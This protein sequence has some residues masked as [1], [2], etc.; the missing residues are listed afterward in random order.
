[1]IVWNIRGASN[2]LARV[3]CKELVRKF[4]PVF[5]IV[6]ETHSPFQHLKLFWE[7]LGYH[8]VGI[9]EAEGHKGG[10]WFLSSM[11][12]VCCKFIDT[13][14]QGVTV[15]VQFDNLIWRCSGIYGSP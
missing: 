1:M 15:E 6:V 2:K 10:I 9:V 7:R 11:K 8:F 12:G 5:F 4:R 14:D 3:H 13:F